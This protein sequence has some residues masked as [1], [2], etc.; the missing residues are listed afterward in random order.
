[1]IALKLQCPPR[2]PLF[3][4]EQW[5]TIANR[6]ELTRRELQIVKLVF[7]DAQEQTIAG[8][9]GV[10]VNTIH[11]HANTWPTRAKLITPSRPYGCTP[12]LEKP[13]DTRRPA[14]F[15]S[16]LSAFPAVFATFLGFFPAG[17]H[18]CR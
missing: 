8:E 3:S 18:L 17:C 15:F 12:V 6:L 4:D 1:M 2:S 10:S 9:L 7:E 5:L 11:T 13:P 16:D 14:S